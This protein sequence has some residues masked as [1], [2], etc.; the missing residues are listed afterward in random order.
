MTGFAT[1][2]FFAPL[3]TRAETTEIQAFT[4][5]HPD[6]RT[7]THGR[8]PPPDDAVHAFDQHPPDDLSYDRQH[9]FLIRDTRT[10]ANAGHVPEAIDLM[11]EGVHHPGFFM[12]ES[13]RQATGF[14]QRLYDARER[15]ALAHGAR[16]LRPCV[17]ARNGRGRRSWTRNGFC[18]VHR[19]DGF[20]LGALRHTLITMVKPLAANRLA[21]FLNAVPR[22]RR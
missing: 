5:A 18:E 13:A 14:A 9:R 4:D 10:G 19:R 20:V 15:H 12:I 6:Y 3:A 2:E 17:V 7:Q 11:A 1:E 8:P 21:D 22:D 16:W